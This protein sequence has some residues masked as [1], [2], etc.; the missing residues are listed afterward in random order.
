M[1]YFRPQAAR[2]ALTGSL[3]GSLYVELS[4]LPPQAPFLLSVLSPSAPTSCG[5]RCEGGGGTFGGTPVFSPPPSKFPLGNGGGGEGGLPCGS[6]SPPVCSYP[7]PALLPPEKNKWC[8]K[9]G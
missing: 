1:H 6:V 9:Q 4:F 8:L 2:V 3:H 5:K 7:G